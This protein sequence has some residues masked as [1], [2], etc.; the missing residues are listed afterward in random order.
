MIARERGERIADYRN[1]ANLRHAYAGLRG[2]GDA[3]IPPAPRGRKALAPPSS[4]PRDLYR[5]FVDRLRKARQERRSFPAQD[6][7]DILRNADIPPSIVKNLTSKGRPLNPFSDPVR[8]V[9]LAA[10]ARALDCPLSRVRRLIWERPKR[11]QKS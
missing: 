3:L 7:D 2:I 9:A 6:A 5:F 10:T 8:E 1:S 4:D 11:H